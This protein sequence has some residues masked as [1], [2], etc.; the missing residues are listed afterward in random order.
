MAGNNSGKIRPYRKPLN[1]NLGTLCFGVIFV[2]III[3]IFLYFTTK[4]VSGYQVKAGSLSVDKVYTG[5]IFREETLVN[6]NYSGYLNYYA[7]EGT[8][9]GAGRMVCTVDEGGRLQNILEEQSMGENSLSDEDLMKL[10][11]DVI[12]FTG[13]FDSRN[14]SSIYDFKYSIEGTV[15]KLANAN[16][17]E[18]LEELNRSG[19]SGLINVC[20]APVSGVVVY[21]YDGYE[22]LKPN[23]ITEDILKKTDYQK[24]QLISNELVK[25]G[26]PIYKLATGENWS[27]V[28][29]TDP[30]RAAFLLEEEYVKVKFLKN[31]YTS[32]GQV[33]LIDN[34]DGNTYV[35]LDFNNSM[36]TFCTERF[37]DIELVL[38]EEEGLKIP[39]SAIVEKEFYMIPEAFVTKSG[40]NG[41][42]GVLR[43]FYLEDGT[44]SQKFV[45]VN[46]YNKENETYYIAGDGLELGT[47]LQKPDSTETHTILDRGTLVGVYNK[48]KGYA[49]FKQIQI[50]YQ[51]E[52]YAIVKSNTEYGLVAYDY[53]VLDAET[54]TDDE[55]INK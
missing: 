17:L 52:E 43:E 30:D 21:S 25:A 11:G 40:E 23:E 45:T 24:T 51:N 46:I 5:M 28:I 33:S 12:E 54:V 4:H 13:D 50:L 14:F 6:S 2:Y 31:Q 18:S 55:F 9:A 37:I 10:R 27:V 36:I 41:E 32:W 3:C 7:R 53:I 16:V 19:E 8:R 44:L 48:N 39:N 15:I 20:A 38:E 49:D 22:S 29:Q 35:Q 26:D 47:I 42:F 34:G 1:V